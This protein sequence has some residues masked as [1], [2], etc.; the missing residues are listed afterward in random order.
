MAGAGR[1]GPAGF[2]Q[3]AVFRG[4]AGIGLAVVMVGINDHPVEKWY[5]DAKL[6]TIFEG[7]SR[8]SAPSSRTRW[9]DPAANAAL[10]MRDRL[11]EPAMK[12]ALGDIRKAT[13]IPRSSAQSRVISP[14]RPRRSPR[15]HA[16]TPPPRTRRR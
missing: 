9:A 15:R 6:N 7:T 2:L 8:S 11:P 3:S 10:G 4:C 12:D 16:G 1:G 14:P 13:T 5:R